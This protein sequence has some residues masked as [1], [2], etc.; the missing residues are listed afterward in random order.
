[1][2][3]IA[4]IPIKTLT[5][6]KGRL[7]GAVSPGD[8]VRLAEAM[9]L[10]T[11]TKL[12]R[13]KRIDESL[14]VTADPYVSRTCR[15]LDVEVLRQSADGS[16]SQAAVAGARAAMGRGAERVAMLPA[17]CPMLDPEELDAKLGTMPQSALIIPD[18]HQNGTNALILSPPDAFAPAFGPDSC[19][20]H[21][22]RARAAEIAFSVTEVS[23]LSLDLDTFEDLVALRDELVIAPERAPR[24]TEV[25]F[26]LEAAV[27]DATGFAAA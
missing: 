18:R 2:K 27:G 15:W 21:V 7:A 6:A 9:F 5:V 25:I 3:T 10:D 8:R 13:S 11:V 26:E 14:V 16:H 23:S 24:T 17:D 1:M 12:R 22:S 20:R 4:I 19:A